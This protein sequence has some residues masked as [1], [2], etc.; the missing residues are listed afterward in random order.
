MQKVFGPVIEKTMKVLSNITELDLKVDLTKNPMSPSQQPN[1]DI[2]G[3]GNWPHEFQEL[4]R[5]CQNEYRSQRCSL[6]QKTT[7]FQ[8]H[9]SNCDAN[10]PSSAKYTI[11]EFWLS[12]GGDWEFIAR[13]LGLTGPNG[14][15]FC[16]F[17]HAQLK[18]LEKGKP[19]T[20]W[21]LQH[22]A[23]ASDTH[24]KKKKKKKATC[25]PPR[26]HLAKQH[27]SVLKF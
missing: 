16:N 19:H 22:G 13:L 7:H 27:L 21:L 23:T 20:S 25:S 2:R 6:C 10:N 8:S 24:T 3:M 1:F 18:D 9:S 26:F 4:F 17:C 12:L 14:T 5:N 11:S 15:F